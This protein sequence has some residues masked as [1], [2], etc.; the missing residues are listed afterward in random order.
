[1]SQRPPLGS[2]GTLRC[3]SVCGGHEA[4]LMKTKA[5]RYFGSHSALNQRRPVAPHQRKV[6]VSLSLS[7]NCIQA[8]LFQTHLFINHPINLWLQM[9][10]WGQHVFPVLRSEERCC[11]FVYTWRCLDS[12]FDSGLVL[13]LSS[14]RRIHFQRQ[15]CPI[16]HT[17]PPQPLI[18]GACTSGGMRRLEFKIVFEKTELLMTP[19]QFAALSE[20]NTADCFDWEIAEV[21]HK[22]R[23]L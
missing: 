6:F 9:K 12:R 23:R 2:A 5:A 22:T 13:F 15:R 21:F 19:N 18:S 16:S 20:M 3:S 1:M 4:V 17:T 14:R 8:S 10:E 11:L 7:P